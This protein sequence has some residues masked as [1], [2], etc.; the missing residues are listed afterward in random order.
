VIPVA[1]LVARRRH[2]EVGRKRRKPRPVP[3]PRQPRGPQM[4]YTTI[5]LGITR[6]IAAAVRHELAAVGVRVDAADGGAPV[7]NPAQVRTIE[8]RLRAVA[9]RA[10]GRPSLVRQLEALAVSIDAF[11]RDEFARQVR[12]ALGIDLSAS[13]PGFRSMVEAFRDRN[14]GLITA[15]ADDQVDKVRKALDKGGQGRRVED[16]A[17]DIREATGVSEDKAALLARD[18]TLKLNAEVT[19][20]RHEAAGITEYVWRT[21]ED[22]RVRPD[23]KAL[24]GTRQAYASPPIVDER[25][26]RRENPGGDYQCRCTAE[27]VIEGFDDDP[28]AA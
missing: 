22:E 14:L 11:S 23:H 25:S 18:Q 1:H 6:E 9:A 17:D 10:V 2:L 21:S 15:L 12:A 7:V 24:D 5:L 3:K 26:G 8:E 13:I 19:Q 28:D 16:L 4:A 20:A 27:P